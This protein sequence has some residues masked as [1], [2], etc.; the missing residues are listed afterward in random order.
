MVGLLLEE[1]NN[2]RDHHPL[3]ASP[4]PSA[5][6]PDTTCTP[7]RVPPPGTHVSRIPG[8]APLAGWRQPRRDSSMEKERKQGF[9]RALKEEVVRGLSPARSRG[10][11]LARSASPAKMLIPRR[12]RSSS[13]SRS[14][15]SRA[16][17]A[18]GRRPRRFHQLVPPRAP[19]SYVDV[20]SLPFMVGRASGL[21]WY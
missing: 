13:T 3:P 4:A 11:T 1:S 19:Q 15:S 18:S 14:S 16:P 20:V 7:V 8:A 5:P 9:F 2:S 17:A 12:R 6:P 10:K 21:L